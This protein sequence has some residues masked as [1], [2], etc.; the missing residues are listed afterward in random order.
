M[1]PLSTL[2]KIPVLSPKL[3]QM[4]SKL[5]SRLS[6]N[7]LLEFSFGK[8]LCLL[9]A[10][11]DSGSK[12]DQDHLS[13]DENFVAPREQGLNQFSFGRHALSQNQILRK[14]AYLNSVD[15][16]M[17][18]SRCINDIISV[19]HKSFSSIKGSTS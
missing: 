9:K 16:K 7:C 6:D 2:I 3:I 14:F 8:R 4:E 10:E 1:D 19:N 17:K 11:D 12:F 15:L 18:K 13:M 5:E